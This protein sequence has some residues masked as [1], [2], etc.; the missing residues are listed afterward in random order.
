MDFFSVMG[1][2]GSLFSAAAQVERGREIRRQKEAEAAQLEQERRQAEINTL[3][4]HNDLLAELDRA[5]DVNTATFGFLNRDDDNSVAA[6][7]AAQSAI[8]D[9]DVRRIDAQGLYAS[10]QLRLRSVGALRAGRAAERSA[11][12][13]AM[14]TIFSGA[15]KAS[16]TG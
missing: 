1:F 10:E 8:S 16:Q 12:L 4:Q 13:N 6:F 14:S 3:Q 7:N 5:E 11:N 15:Y 9:R 2:A